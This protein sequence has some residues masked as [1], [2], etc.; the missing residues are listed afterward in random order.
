MLGAE[1]WIGGDLLGL[2]NL[3]W[4]VFRESVLADYR[5]LQRNIL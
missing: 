4:V 1:G 3:E 5:R 2:L